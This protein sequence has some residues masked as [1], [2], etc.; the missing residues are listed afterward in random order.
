MRLRCHVD[1]H[2]VRVAVF[3]FRFRA[4]ANIENLAVI[5]AAGGFDRFAGCRDINDQKTAS[6]VSPCH[7]RLVH[8]CG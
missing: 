3:T 8:N 2:T 7:P 6:P 4:A 5:G 1:H